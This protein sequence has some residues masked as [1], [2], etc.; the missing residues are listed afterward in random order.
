MGDCGACLEA[1]LRVPLFF[2]LFLYILFIVAVLPLMG[3][4]TLLPVFISA[5]CPVPSF[6]R[7]LYLSLSTALPPFSFNRARI[8][9]SLSFCFR[10]RVI[11]MKARLC[12]ARPDARE[13][14]SPISSRL[15]PQDWKQGRRGVESTFRVF[16]DASLEI[17]LFEERQSRLDV[18]SL[19]HASPALFQH[20]PK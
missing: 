4:P 7:S 11:S 2:L 20:H 9:P 5:I 15:E 14:C 16:N 6:R 17:S 1:L 18:A 3:L 13:R 8:V 19:C 12:S 10:L